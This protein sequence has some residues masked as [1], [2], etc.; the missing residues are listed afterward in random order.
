MPIEEG[1]PLIGAMPTAFLLS[2]AE[3]ESKEAAALSHAWR[4]LIET[5]AIATPS[6]MQDL[7]KWPF[8][9]LGSLPERPALP[10]L[11]SEE[12]RRELQDEA[13]VKA[14]ESL[15]QRARSWLRDACSGAPGSPDHAALWTAFSIAFGTAMSRMIE[16]DAGSWVLV[17]FLDLV[18]PA[19]H[20][21][22]TADFSVKIANCQL[23]AE[24]FGEGG[25]KLLF[26]SAVR[27]LT[28]GEALT[29]SF[30]DL[31]A[32]DLLLEH[33]L[34]SSSGSHPLA[35]LPARAYLEEGATEAW[36]LQAV[37]QG[38]DGA[39]PGR[40]QGDVIVAGQLARWVP[41]MT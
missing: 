40:L 16:A 23:H 1:T 25:K 11:W 21:N 26:L 36:K 24:D 20:S 9:Y 19:G 10:L 37:L 34:V 41:K 35:S 2:G 33:G 29:R 32:E 7:P 4:T 17:P 14:I 30:D 31:S 28:P 5:G 8:A 3:T 15:E 38:V 12:Q 22:D 13:L 6:A 27:S 18:G 39:R